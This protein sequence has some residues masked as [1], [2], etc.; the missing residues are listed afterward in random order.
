M[1]KVKLGWEWMRFHFFTNK[2][3]RL[4]VANVEFRPLGFELYGGPNSIILYVELGI[5]TLMLK[6]GK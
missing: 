1:I 5:G 4:L 3:S 2:M 6:L